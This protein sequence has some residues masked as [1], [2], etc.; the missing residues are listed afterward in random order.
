MKAPLTSGYTFTPASRVVDFTTLSPAFD[1][2][3]LTAIIN[4]KTGALM[5]ATGAPAFGYTSLAGAVLTLAANTTAMSASDPLLIIYDDSMFEAAN[6]GRVTAAQ[7]NAG[8]SAQAWFTKL[9]DTTG[10]NVAQVTSSSALKVDG[11]AVTQPISAAALPLPAGAA[12]AAKQ[13]AL[14]TAGVSSA[15]V[16][17][18]QGR[19][20][21]TPITVTLGPAAAALADATAN[22]TTGSVQSFGMLWN[23][24]TWDRQRAASAD[25]VAATGVPAMGPMI[26]DG[27][28]YTR[29]RSPASDAL[30]SGGLPSAAALVFNGTGWDRV[31]AASGDAMAAT[32]MPAS[33]VMGWNGLTWDRL[34]STTAN[35]LQVDVTR[36]QGSVAVTGTF[37]Q[38]TQPVSGTLAAT[39]SGAWTVAATQSGA[40]TVTQSGA[41]SVT[42]NIGTTGGLALDATLTGGTARTKITDGTT[43]AAVK[44]AST[45]AAA[46]DPALVVAISPNNSVAVT[47]TFWQATQPVSGTVTAN[48]GTVAGLALDATISNGTQRTR[49]TDGINNVVVRAASSLPAATDTALVV[50]QRDTLTVAKHAVTIAAADVTGNPS[51]SISN[52][53]ATQAVSGTFWQATQPISAAALPLP[54]GAA[55]DGTDPSVPAVANQ[56]VGIRGWLATIAAMLKRGVQTSANSTSVTVASDQ[57]NLEPAGVPITGQAMPTG[58]VG[59]TGWLSGIYKLLNSATPAGTNTIGAVTQAGAPWTISLPTNAAQDGTDPGVPGVANQGTGIRG[60][61]ATIAA[62]LKLGTQ[63]KAASASVTIATDQGN[64]EPGGTAITGVSMPTGGIGLTGWLSALYQA[65]VA[66]TPAGTNVIGAV[67]QSGTW[68]INTVASITAVVTTKPQVGGVDI[69]TTNPVP[70]D[71]RPRPVTPTDKSGTITTAATA[72]QLAAANANRRGFLIHNISAGDLWINEL[73]TAA[74]VQPSLKLTAGTYYEYPAHGVPAGAISIFGGTAGQ[75]WTAREW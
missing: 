75:A 48:L 49:V 29:Q 18:V 8:T 42:A 6:P 26:F 2:R 46:I 47:G 19:T 13:P 65:L 7:G 68:A 32:G 38:A 22:P 70:V 31:R 23:G 28:T 39:Q 33:A 37:W 9:V 56:G 53:P 10:T 59:L 61:L 41:W 72:Q 40:W 57:S 30:S 14:G 50:T 4:I 71:V 11:S 66:A 67:T 17:T 12:T 27:S 36:V 1:I 73:G 60:W 44:A 51:F 64:L 55:Q 58:G 63:N 43:N 54:A 69:S 15:D 5:Y 52:L 74:A 16:L 62:L 20:G 35:G 34:K 25:G 45:A 21:M 24:T 3:N